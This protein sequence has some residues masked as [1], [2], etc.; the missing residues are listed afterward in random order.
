MFSFLTAWSY[1]A[2]I[3][4]ILIS[5]NIP[6][7]R[8]LKP[9]YYLLHGLCIGIILSSVLGL[10]E[11]NPYCYSSIIIFDSYSVVRLNFLK[12]VCPFKNFLFVFSVILLVCLHDIHNESKASLILS[13][14]HHYKE[15][16]ILLS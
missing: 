13:T 1:N 16:S 7:H 6:A 12:R 3:S 14:L 10:K 8:R 11:K 4:C 5:Q 15:S 9:D 2:L